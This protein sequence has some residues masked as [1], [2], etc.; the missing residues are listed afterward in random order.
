[1]TWDNHALPIGEAV[2]MTRT[3]LGLTHED[4]AA[5]TGVHRNTLLRLEKGE[6]PPSIPVLMRISN[7]L[8]IELSK[9]LRRAEALRPLGV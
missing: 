9:L 3:Q 1:M 4:I 8:G 2:F 5:K 6:K 7:A